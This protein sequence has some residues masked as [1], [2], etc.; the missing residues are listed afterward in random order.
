MLDRILIEVS[1]AITNRIYNKAS[2]RMLGNI[3]EETG[4]DVTMF[5]IL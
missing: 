2:S 1:T 5:F 4:D 3:A